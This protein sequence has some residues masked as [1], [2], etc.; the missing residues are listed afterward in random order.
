MSK[1]S[2]NNECKP[3]NGN[4]DEKS[5][6]RSEY[7]EFLIMFILIIVAITVFFLLLKYFSKLILAGIGGLFQLFLAM[8]QQTVDK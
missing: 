1:L 6:G 5:A 2:R 7:I 4:V 8:S 3:N